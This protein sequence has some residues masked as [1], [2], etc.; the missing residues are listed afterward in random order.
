[1]L[2]EDF[3]EDLR[4]LHAL[5]TIVLTRHNDV[6]WLLELPSEGLLSQTYIK[7]VEVKTRIDYPQRIQRWLRHYHPGTTN[8]EV[9]S[10]PLL[11][12]VSVEEPEIKDGDVFHGIRACQN[13]VKEAAFDGSLWD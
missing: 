10:I 4:Q 3:K 1:M 8:F 6:E 9:Q 12:L 7:F 2:P 11:E 13:W 5:K